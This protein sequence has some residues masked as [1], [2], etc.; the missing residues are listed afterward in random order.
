MKDFDWIDFKNGKIVVHCDTEEKSKDFLKECDKQGIKWICGCN[1]SKHTYW[2]KER[3][4]LTYM[5]YRN[6][7]KY[8]SYKYF[9]EEDEEIIK[10]EIDTMEELNFQE[11]I[12]NIKEGETWDSGFIIIKMTDRHIDIE[13]NYAPMG[14][15]YSIRKDMKFKLKRKEY[16]FQEAFKAYEE[17]KE[18]ESK[19]NTIRYKKIKNELT[20]FSKYY[21]SWVKSDVGFSVNSIREKWYIN[22]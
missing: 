9:K 6:N 12:A 4:N 16:S 3:E 11:V 17:G 15:V 21:G 13:F 7:L 8:D 2:K 1:A 20:C 10:W 22:D 5:C 19:Y 14:D 18:I